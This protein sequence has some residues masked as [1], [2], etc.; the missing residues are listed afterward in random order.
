MAYYSLRSLGT[1][2]FFLVTVIVKCL[3]GRTPNIHIYVHI[4]I[5]I[6]KSILDIFRCMIDNDE[7]NIYIFA[8]NIQIIQ[9]YEYILT[10]SYI[11]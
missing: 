11:A 5:H 1:L 4:Y 3:H 8:S 9:L 10:D 2:L 6:Y 7:I